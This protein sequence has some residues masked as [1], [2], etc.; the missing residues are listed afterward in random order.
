MDKKYAYW[1][2]NLP[3]IGD[4]SIRKLLEVCGGT[5]RE[6][7]YAGEK[8][9]REVLRA[10]QTEHMKESTINWDLEGKYAELKQMGIGFCTREESC[11][12]E[13]LKRIPDP[14]YGLY[15]R[16]RLPV[17]EQMSVAIIGARDCSQYGSYVA[18]HLGRFLGE[19][20]IQIIS[21]MAKGI[22]GISQSAAL[23]AGGTSFGVLGCGVDICYPAQNR[24]LYDNLQKRGGVIS[25]FPPG[26][27]AKPGNFPPRNRIVSGLADAVVVIEARQKSGTLI[28]VDMA[29]EQ[30]KEVYVVPGRI[31]DQL[32]DGCN[33]LLKQGAGVLVSFSEFLE[34][35]PAEQQAYMESYEDITDFLEWYR[36]AEEKY[37]SENTYTEISGGDINIG[38]YVD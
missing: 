38:E 36:A 26:T 18:A 32:S 21:G 30:G 28:T 11:Y 9:W 10:R 5:P 23:E 22:D 3:G 34:M 29:L 20:G 37:K 1:I 31:T 2:C 7:Y 17:E 13:R 33:N 12:P 19:K 16:G 15:Y 14:P 8:K 25:S 6:V 27:L 4:R 35:S 24:G